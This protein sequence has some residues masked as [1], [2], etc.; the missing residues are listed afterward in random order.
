MNPYLPVLTFHRI[1]EKPSVIS[2]PPRLFE[3]LIEMLHANGFRTARLTDAAGFVNRGEPFPDKTFVLTFDDGYGSVYT[4]VF[5]VLRK[6]GMTATVFLTVG[7]PDKPGPGGRMPP[8]NG[9]D[10]LDWDEVSEMKA[11]GF[12]FGAHTLTHPDLTGLGTVE[13]ER[14][15]VRS[16]EIIEQKLG[17]PVRSFAYPYGK[18]DGR[19]VDIAARFFDCACSDE[20]GLLTRGSNLHALERVDAYYLRSGRLSSLMLS[21]FFPHYVRLRNIPRKILRRMNWR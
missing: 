7:D 4:E 5:P 2:Y 15:I 3:T 19:C 8:L 13:A 14:E 21:G 6:Y 17:A 9:S 16:K 11:G 18:Y 20:L 12:D 10:M 1:D